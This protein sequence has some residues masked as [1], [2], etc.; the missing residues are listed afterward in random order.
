MIRTTSP[1]RRWA[2]DRLTI[3]GLLLTT[4]LGACGDVTSLKQDAPSRVLAGDLQNPQNAALLVDGAVGDFECALGNYIVAGGLIT[5]ELLD[6]QLG[7]AGWEYDRRTLFPAAQLYLPAYGCGNTQFLGVYTPVSVARFQGDQAVRL[8]DGWTDQ[9]VPKRTDLI[10]TASAYAGYSLVLLAEGMCSAAIDLGPELSRTQ[11]AAEALKRFDRAIT[12]GT[13]SGNTAVVTLSHLGKARALLDQGKL[14]EAAT[15][16]ALVPDGFVFNAT[17]NATPARRENRVYTQ[18]WRDNFASVDPTFRN[19]TWAGQADPRVTVMDAG[20]KGH[21]RSTEVFRTTKYPAITTPIPVGRTA[22]ARL[23][24][25]EAAVASGKLQQAVD[26]I[27]ALHQKAG[28]AP[29]AG[30]SAA[31]VKA[32]VLEERR[33]ELFLEGQRLGDVIRNNVAL[34]PA[35]GTPYPKGGLYGTQVCLPLPDVERNNNPNI[36]GQS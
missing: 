2:G 11:L 6:A 8:L 13:K 36:G 28:I 18:L 15:E 31:E 32:Q 12:E 4:T 10:A 21:D 22:E 27:N 33:R 5:D 30:G 34:Q 14:S 26:I 19:L 35:A 17:F 16:A 24:Q 23:I 20:A 29:Y 25:A 7:Q 1:R 9:D 3:L